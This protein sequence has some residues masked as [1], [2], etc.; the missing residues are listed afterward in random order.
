MLKDN[1]IT[2]KTKLYLPMCLDVQLFCFESTISKQQIEVL[3]LLH[4]LN[5]LQP[6]LPVHSCFKFTHLTY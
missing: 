4:P 3:T 2:L 1:N 6:V 5:L